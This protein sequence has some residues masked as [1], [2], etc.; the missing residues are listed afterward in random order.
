MSK[1]DYRKFYDP[2]PEDILKIE[3]SISENDK[4]LDVGSWW[5]PLNRANVIIDILPYE[6]RG[7]G[8]S[9]GKQKEHFSK[10]TWIELDICSGKWP[11]KNHEFDF[12]H[13]GQTLEDV[14]DPIFVC[15]E[16]MR[17]AKRGVLT[18]PTIWIECQKGIDAYPESVL[19]RGF[20]KHRWLVNYKKNSLKFIPKLT[21]L[22]AFEY[23]DET[24]VKK[25]ITRHRIW[26]DIFF[27]ENRFEVSEASFQGF[28]ELKPMLDDYF[29]NFD[30]EKITRQ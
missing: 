7:E 14:R 30:Y 25:Y 12:V 6:T 4:V 11:F 16:M 20:D 23:T 21:S 24:T 19:Y 8:G 15:N 3:K 9:I 17:I 2:Y 22:M 27:W 5:K 13:C 18:T 1:I 29:A 26:S 28:I 10:N